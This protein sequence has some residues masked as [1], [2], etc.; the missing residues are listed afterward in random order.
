MDASQ[1]CCPNKIEDKI[2]T[3]MWDETYSDHI[4]VL[5][6]LVT[7]ARAEKFKEVL[8]GFIQATWTQSNS[9]RPVEGIARDKFM[10]QTLEVSK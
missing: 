4:Q 8:N 5:V 1:E 7:R 3:S 6:G 10:I 2:V 9:W